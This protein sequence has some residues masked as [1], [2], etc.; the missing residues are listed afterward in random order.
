MQGEL[1]TRRT[2][3][4]GCHLFAQAGWRKNVGMDY[5]QGPRTV[6]MLSRFGRGGEPLSVTCQDMLCEVA[7][8]LL[9]VHHP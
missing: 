6:V 3:S 8:W 1:A 4:R 2:H 7:R 9:S 5:P